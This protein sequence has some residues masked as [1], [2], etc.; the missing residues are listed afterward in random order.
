[1]LTVL[2][3]LHSEIHVFIG[4]IQLPV[5]VWQ[6]GDALSASLFKVLINEGGACVCGDRPGTVAAAW[7]SKLRAKDGAIM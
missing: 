3:F 1:L 5:A 7:Y 6:S 2:A 4:Q